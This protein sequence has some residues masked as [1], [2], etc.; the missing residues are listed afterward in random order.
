MPIKQVVSIDAR[1]TKRKAV[2]ATQK[3]VD[4]LPF[5]S[6]TWRVR[7]ISGL[8]LR[9]RAVTKSFYIQR[10]IKGD[11]VKSTLG[12]LALKDAR[13]A[14]MK[15]WGLLKPVPAGG[16]K[17][18]EQ[19]FAEFITQRDLA[20]K[21]KELYNFNADHYLIDWK[22]RA[23]EDIGRDR[24]GVR[25]L[26]HSIA[27][28]HGTATGSQVIRMFSAVYRYARKV[29]GDLPESPTVAVS[30]PAT[31]SRDWAMSPEALKAWWSSTEKDDE[32]KEIPRGVKTLG[33][34]KRAW[35]LTTLLTGARRGSVEALRWGDV[36]LGKKTI[37]FKVTKGD[38]PYMVPMSDKLADLLTKYRASGDVPPSEWLFPSA[39]NGEHHIVNVRDDKRGVA[40]AHHLR[41]TFRTI[42]AQLGASPDQARLLMGHS[43]S[44]DVSRGYIT[45][46]LLVESLRPITNAVSERLA[47]IIGD[48]A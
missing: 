25:A 9:C 35:W 41:H 42:L 17:T 44:G 30:L 10:R 18:F 38:R 7:G 47:A 28:K 40:S 27:K 16:R 22:P 12:E 14:A 6:G 8:Y 11:L 15:E 13:A 46:G 32:G 31:K 20:A 37:T 1:K 33:P 39:V 21:T 2:A 29:D 3:A 48:M 4:A 36:D 24:T 45:A 23:L 26:Y 43:M 34:I 19:A 5:N